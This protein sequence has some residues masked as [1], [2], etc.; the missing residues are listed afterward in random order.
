MTLAFIS[1]DSKIGGFFGVKVHLGELYAEHN[2]KR[3]RK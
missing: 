2:S 1:H 3:M